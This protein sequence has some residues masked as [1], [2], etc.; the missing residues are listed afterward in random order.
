MSSVPAPL[1]LNVRGDARLCVPAALDQ[2]TTYVLLEQEDWFEDEIRFVRRWLQRGMRAVDVGAN[3]GVYTVAM[4]QAV[5][6]SGRVWAFE[7]TPAAADYLQRSLGLNGF[8]NV[9]VSRAAVSDREGTVAFSV[10]NHSELNAVA[11]PGSAGS[12][13]VPVRAVTLDRMATEHGWTTMDLIKLDVEGHESEAIR[14]GARFLASAS[15]VLMVEIKA[16]DRVNLD[17][18]DLVMEM[19]YDVYRLL[20]GPLMLTPFDHRF[21]QVDGYLLNVFACKRDRAGRLAADGLLAGSDAAE[22]AAPAKDAWARFMHGAPYARELAAGWPAKAGFFST[23]DRRTYAEGLNAFALSRDG[24]RDPAERLAWL[25]RAFQCVAEALDANDTVGRRISYVRLAA[26]LGW[27]T[28]AVGALGMVMD[29]ALGGDPKVLEEPFLAP[30]A[31]HER[32]GTGANA[33]GWLKCA[34]LEEFERQREFSS[35]YSQTTSLGIIARI[36]DLPFRSTEMERRRQ[37]VRMRHGMQDRPEP[38]AI[39]R[40]RSEDNLNPQYWSGAA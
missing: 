36:G 24:G 14:G 12:D 13:I 6:S 28:A 7:P 15:P 2:I 18:L 21:E 16:G 3:I 4:A 23:P 5:G 11:K 22:S 20:P 30:S 29:R 27:R 1:V 19:G 25:S 39:L 37:L 10:G 17:V 33:P 8:E 31:R 35:L 40:E 38:A 32:I 9:I 34:L 26:E